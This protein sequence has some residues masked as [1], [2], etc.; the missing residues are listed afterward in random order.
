[1]QGRRL[2]EP[3]TVR[4]EVNKR[5]DVKLHPLLAG[6]R[7]K[8]GAVVQVRVIS[9]DAIGAVAKFRMRKGKLPVR[10]TLCMPPGTSKPK[11]CA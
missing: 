6:R 10:K 4:R 2:P 3:R 7:L 9:S 1:M 11:K 5:K 8:P